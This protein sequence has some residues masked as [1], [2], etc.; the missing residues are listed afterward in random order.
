VWLVEDSVST[1]FLSRLVVCLLRLGISES[2]AQLT[3]QLVKRTINHEEEDT[4]LEVASVYREIE[5]PERA[6]NFIKSLIDAKRIQES[7]KSLYLLGTLYQVRF[8]SRKAGR[9]IH[10]VNI[11]AI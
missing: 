5:S 6:I 9:K 1:K 3:D 2:A 11:C 10:N 4:V 7:P 8:I